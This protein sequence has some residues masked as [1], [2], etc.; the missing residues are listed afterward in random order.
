MHYHGAHYYHGG[1]YYI[2]VLVATLHTLQ[3]LKAGDLSPEYLL[4]QKLAPITRLQLAE[5]LTPGSV[6]FIE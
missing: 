2:S 6:G 5:G 3:Q 4:S 1:H